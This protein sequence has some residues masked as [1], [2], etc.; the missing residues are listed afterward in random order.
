M[1]ANIISTW[2]VYVYFVISEETHNELKL[3]HRTALV[4]V[5]IS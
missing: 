3:D 1:H 5:Y 4:M 2:N